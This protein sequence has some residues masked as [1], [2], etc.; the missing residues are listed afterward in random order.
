MVFPVGN[1]GRL[2]PDSSRVNE[3]VWETARRAMND[4]HELK[5]LDKGIL[6]WIK[7]KYDLN[8]GNDYSSTNSSL[9][10]LDFGE[11]KSLKMKDMRFA[12]KQKNY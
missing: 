1:D 8:I 7:Y 9:G 11:F 6:Y 2:S 12:Y 4:I 3:T 5:S 10:I